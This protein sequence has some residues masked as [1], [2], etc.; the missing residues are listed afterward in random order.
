MSNMV[1]CYARRFTH[2]VYGP[3]PFFWCL[4]QNPVIETVSCCFF[5]NSL[6]YKISL[7]AVFNC[8]GQYV[9]RYRFDVHWFHHH[10]WIGGIVQYCE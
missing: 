2:I 9:V 1:C 6:L 7:A 3:G 10:A 4:S 8:P 5:A